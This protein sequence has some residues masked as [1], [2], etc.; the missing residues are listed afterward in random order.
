MAGRLMSMLPLTTDL[1]GVS[2]PSMSSPSNPDAPSKGPPR[3]ACCLLRCSMISRKV[4]S[5]STLP[6]AKDSHALVSHLAAARDRFAIETARTQRQRATCA[7]M[8]SLLAQN[9]PAACAAMQPLLTPC[10]LSGAFS[11]STWPSLPGCAPA[12]SDPACATPS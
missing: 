8:T 3:D 1:K 11:P 4:M 7:G 12:T 9:G 5:R 6:P 2:R 10:T